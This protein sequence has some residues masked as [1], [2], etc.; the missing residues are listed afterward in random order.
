M[1]KLVE[2]FNKVYPV[3]ASNSFRESCDVCEPENQETHYFQK[4]IL[5]GFDGYIFPHEI[6]GKASSFASMAKHHGVLTLDCDGVIL[7]EHNNQKY[8]LLCELKSS[9]LCDEIAKAKNQ[10][11]GSSVKMKSLISSLQGFDLSDFKTIGLIVSFEPTDEQ[12]TN[13]SKNEDR[14]SSFAISLQ[15]NKRYT[16]PDLKTNKFFY[17]LNIGTID[18]YYVPVPNR[19]TSY[20]VDVKSWLK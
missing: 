8:I 13:L 17:P 14:K 16:M 4:L 11:V 12:I 19:Q 20:A 10:I 7:F 5:T 3:F 15:A 2:N 18:L 1:K 9:Y 6:M